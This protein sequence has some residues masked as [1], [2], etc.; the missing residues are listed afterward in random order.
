MQLKNRIFTLLITLILLCSLAGSAFADTPA[1]DMNRTNGILTVHIKDTKGNAVAGGVLTLY[2]VAQA[3]YVGDYPGYTL[4]AD[5]SGCGVVL[6]DYYELDQHEFK[7]TEELIQKFE[8]HAVDNKLP[9]TKKTVSSKGEVTFDSLNMGLYLVVQTNPVSNYTT[10]KSFLIS[11]PGW[12]AE[13]GQWLYTV[14]AAPK[15]GTVTRVDTPD[16]P[17]PP[18]TVPN[19][20]Y[21]NQRIPFTGQV[22]WPVWV[23][24]V[25]GVLL[26]SVGI[27]LK[28]RGTRDA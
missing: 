6:S 3:G 2:Q 27:V 12:N 17:E 20:P 11:L 5:F 25:G 22:W 10:L 28:K 8:K 1:P 19:N 18:P 14:D 9:G 15:I 21:V 4:T 7:V 13:N 23:L 16:T 24:A 26:V